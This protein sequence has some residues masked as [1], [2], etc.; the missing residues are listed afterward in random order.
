M[1]FSKWLTV[2]A[3]AATAT[4]ETGALEAGEAA[5]LELEENDQYDNSGDENDTSNDDQ[6][7]LP[8]QQRPGATWRTTSSIIHRIERLVAGVF[9]ELICRPT[10]RFS[11][12]VSKTYGSRT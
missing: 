6:S 7:Y 3:A 11:S 2:V 4:V 12:D 10:S 8:R 5:A 9:L 1:K